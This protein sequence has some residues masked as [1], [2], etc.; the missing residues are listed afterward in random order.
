MN[1]TSKNLK[2]LGAGLLGTAMLL[3]GGCTNYVKRTDLDAALAELRAR[4][5]A[6][7]QKADANASALASLRQELSERF[8]QYDKAIAEAQGKLRIDAMAHFDYDSTTLRDED[9][10]ALEDFARVIR[11]HH[12][13]SLITVE[14][15]TDPAGS[16]GYNQRLGKA[17]A[18]AVREHLVANGLAADSVRAVSYGEAANRLVAPGAWGDA[19]TA[20]R[21][22]TLVVDRV[23][24]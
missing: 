2:L 6:I 21:R 24:S 11:D 13:G 16:S 3:A 9:K 14:G 12:P 10:P 1:P 18:E 17:R 20:N 7:E 22:V 15:F 23:G 4:D 5:N 19:G 8:A